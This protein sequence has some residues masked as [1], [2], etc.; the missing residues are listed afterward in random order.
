[1]AARHPVASNPHYGGGR[2]QRPPKSI[3]T[4][5]VEGLSWSLAILSCFVIV[6]T[7]YQWTAHI[8]VRHLYATVSPEYGELYVVIWWGILIALCLYFSLAVLSTLFTRIM[9]SRI[10]GR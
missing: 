4:L 9:A 3:F 1:M 2:A 6:P 5:S 8:F 10:I 7:L